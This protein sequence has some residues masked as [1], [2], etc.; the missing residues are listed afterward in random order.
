MCNF[1]LTAVSSNKCSG[2]GSMRTLCVELVAPS[3]ISI[4]NWSRSSWRNRRFKGIGQPREGNKCYSCVC[5]CERERERERETDRQ[6]DRNISN[7]KT[8]VMA[9]TDRSCW[10]GCVYS[11]FY[12]N[13]SSPLSRLYLART[14]IAVRIRRQNGFKIEHHWCM[15]LELHESNTRAFATPEC[16]WKNNMTV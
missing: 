2:S 10:C 14:H 6:T 11:F 8:K 12:R 13:L 15:F 4:L 7:G 16:R 5:V 3:A 1:H 9:V